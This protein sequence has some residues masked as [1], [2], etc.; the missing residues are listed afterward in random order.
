MNHFL[1]AGHQELDRPKLLPSSHLH[2]H[3]H[4]GNHPS[5]PPSSGLFISLSVGFFL[6]PWRSYTACVCACVCV[7]FTS[8]C[9]YVCVDEALALRLRSSCLTDGRACARRCAPSSAPGGSAHN[10]AAS[11]SLLRLT[12][13]TKERAGGTRVSV[14]VCV[15][16]YGSVCF[17]CAADHVSI[18]AI[19]RAAAL[20]QRPIPIIDSLSFPSFFFY[21]SCSAGMH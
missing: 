9:V 10:H 6:P 1:L 4:V 18:K 11:P 2:A 5:I 13:E 15:R 20:H 12:R 14:C 16:A 7:L 8:L 17:T 19:R 3:L 21:P